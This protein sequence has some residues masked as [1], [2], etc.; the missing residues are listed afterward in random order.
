MKL[1]LWILRD[2]NVDVVD[3]VSYTINFPYF[4]L[5]PFHGCTLIHEAN[6]SW[7][8]GW[9]HSGLRSRSV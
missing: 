6:T 8:L 4:P 7:M 3:N 2:E 9:L 1:W 5:E